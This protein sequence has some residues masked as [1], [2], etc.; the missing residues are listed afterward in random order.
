MPSVKAPGAI[1]SGMVF[2]VLIKIL[3]LIKKRSLKKKRSLLNVEY[4]MIEAAIPLS[5]YKPD[6]KYVHLE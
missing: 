3:K 2:E 5:E 1:L 4:E 6:G